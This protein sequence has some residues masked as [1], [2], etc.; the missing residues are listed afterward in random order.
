[1]KQL[2]H[3]S[4]LAFSALALTVT[5]SSCDDDNLKGDG[6]LGYVGGSGKISGVISNMGELAGTGDYDIVLYTYIGDAER[7][8]LTRAAVSDDG[9]FSL[10]APAVVP[11]KFLVQL[12]TEVSSLTVSNENTL[13]ANTYLSLVNEAGDEYEVYNNSTYSEDAESVVFI[14]PA[15]FSAAVDVT[16]TVE[17]Y[18]GGT[19]TFDWHAKAGWGRIYNVV[20]HTGDAAILTTTMPSGYEYGYSFGVPYGYSQ[21]GSEEMRLSVMPAAARPMLPTR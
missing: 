8:E 15:F 14:F 4:L 13:M 9:S 21:G 2:F 11:E 3:L 1:M 5:Q 19:L 18:G 20:S 16:G 12:T 6:G 10:T 7:E 17:Q